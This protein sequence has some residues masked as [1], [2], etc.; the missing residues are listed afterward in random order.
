[1]GCIDDKNSISSKFKDNFLNILSG[2]VHGGYLTDKK[3]FANKLTLECFKAGM[4][5]KLDSS[6]ISDNYDITIR[7]I[8][9]AYAFLQF[10]CGVVSI[11]DLSYKLMLLPIAFCLVDDKCWKDKATLDK[12]EFWYWSSIFSARYRDFQNEKSLEDCKFLFNYLVLGK[13]LSNEMKDSLISRRDNIFS[14]T[15]Y[16]D[17]KTLTREDKNSKVPSAIHNT[18]LQYILSNTPRDFLP[19]NQYEEYRLCAWEIARCI[20]DDYEIVLTNKNGTKEHKSIKLQDHHIFPLGAAKPL[21]SSTKDLRKQ[22]THPLN[23]PLNRT[24]I[25]SFA[26]GLISSMIPEQY[27]SY[28]D[29][30]ALSDHLSSKFNSVKR[31]P[32][33][34][35]NSFYVRILKQ[36]FDILKMKIMTELDNLWKL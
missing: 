19:K 30:K 34:D 16:C 15:T 24:Y 10:R 22:E 18:I 17:I 23:S 29:D 13:P 26:N 25:S 11:N 1:M 21:N 14:S 7:A 2:F 36:R 9:R 31:N 35:E 27:F 28:I 20:N 3:N 5:L 4:Q 8:S 12:L 6:Q 32:N 33:E